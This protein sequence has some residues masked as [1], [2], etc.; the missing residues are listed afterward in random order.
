MSAEAAWAEPTLVE[1]ELLVMLMAAH[2]PPMV[3]EGEV[4]LPMM[5]EVVREPL[6]VVWKHKGLTDWT[7]RLANQRLPF[8]QRYSSDRV[9]RNSVA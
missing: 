8:C 6:G 5:S 3:G 9:C 4:G 2:E 1:A 7:V